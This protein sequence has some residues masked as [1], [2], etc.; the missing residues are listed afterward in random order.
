MNDI[1]QIE[2]QKK[3]TDTM[4]LLRENHIESMRLLREKHTDAMQL[5]LEKHTDAMLLILESS[6]KCKKES[7]LHI[8]LHEDRIMTIKINIQDI[9]SRRPK[10]KIYFG[11]V[12]TE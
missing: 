11:K 12:K 7:Q 8:Q 5:I 9:L 3:H 4:Q 1:K 10:R 2:Q 6:E